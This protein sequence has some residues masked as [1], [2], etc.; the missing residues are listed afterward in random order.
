MIWSVTLCILCGVQAL[1]AQQDEGASYLRQGDS[2]YERKAFDCA[3]INYRTYIELYKTNPSHIPAYV[4]ERYDELNKPIKPNSESKAST[5]KKDP[6]PNAGERNNINTNS[7]NVGNQNVVGNGNAVTYNNT[8][9]SYFINS[10]DQNKDN[11]L[12]PTNRNTSSLT[13]LFPVLKS[14]I[15][16]Y[17]QCNETIN[18]QSVSYITDQLPG[19]ITE[20]GIDC[21]F[22]N[23]QDEAD[24]VIRIDARLTRCNDAPYNQVFCY[25]T[26]SIKVYNTHTQKT[27]IPKIAE[28][29][30][31]WTNGNKTLATE[32]AFKELVVIIAEN[33]TPIIK[34]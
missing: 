9:N 13:N 18:G 32:E 30:G 23:S 20:K 27:V 11:R 3:K 4:K 28:S 14:G 6:I 17:L 25:A 29:K 33:I 31:G 19:I 12:L 5:S 16:I 34:N 8:N 15:S 21:N 24:Y 10:N 1:Y 26:A 7:N 2:C 22:T